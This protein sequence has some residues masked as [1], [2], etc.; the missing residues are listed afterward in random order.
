MNSDENNNYDDSNIN[1][2]NDKILIALMIMMMMRIMIKRRKKK[3]IIKDKRR[4]PFPFP[5]LSP[6]PPHLTLP[7]PSPPP[8]KR[9]WRSKF[10]ILYNLLGT[11]QSAFNSQ[12][13]QDDHINHDLHIW[14]VSR[15]TCC[16]PRGATCWVRFRGLL[17]SGFITLSLTVYII[18]NN[19]R[20][21]WTIW[22]CRPM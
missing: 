11:L 7:R 10:H 14:R 5:T 4:L 17:L 18:C 9:H 12:V 21:Y 22:V 19:P 3:K 16:A 6:P 2:N 20:F 8:Q 1:S 15:T 13:L